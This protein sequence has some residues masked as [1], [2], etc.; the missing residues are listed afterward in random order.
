MSPADVDDFLRESLCG[1]KLVALGLESGENLS[2]RAVI[3]LAGE[4]QA[5]YIL[6]SLEGRRLSLVKEHRL[7]WQKGARFFEDALAIWESVQVDGELVEAH[8]QLLSELSELSR[9]RVEYYAVS[10]SD[11]RNYTE[12]REIGTELRRAPSARI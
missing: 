5:F 4:A 12:R 1:H 11:R 7:L 8:W 9:D 6:L 3:Q 10:E 2:D